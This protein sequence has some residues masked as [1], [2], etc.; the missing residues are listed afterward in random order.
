MS[1]STPHT[2]EQYG[3]R[4]ELHRSLSFGDL[5]VYGLVFM[6]P[7]APFG[8]FGGVFQGSGGMV[9]L[10]YVIG[11]VAMMFTALSYAQMSRA[12]PMAGSVYTYAGRGIAPQIGFLSG[13]MILL[14]YVLVPGLLYLIASVAMNS[15][16]SAVP[17]W[18][19]LIGF[20]VL[21]TVV[22]YMGIEMTAK[23]NRVMLVGELVVLAIFIV[24]G[25][26]AL[27]QGKGRGFDI[28]PIYNAHTFSWSLVFG[29]VSI[30]VLSFLGFDGI[31]MLAEENKESARAIG[32]SMIAA[33]LLAGVLF[34][35]QTWIAA[36]LVPH[37]GALIAKGDP[38]G[39]AFYDSA[40]VA[41]GAWLS[42]LTALA[43]A[44]AWGF[45]N[46]LVAQ[47]ATSRLLYAMARDRQLPSFLAKVHPSKGVPVNATFLTAVVSLALGLYFATRDDGI[48]LL[49]TL[50]NFGALTAF[51]ALHVSVVVHYV[52]RNG[53]RAWW[54]HLF[55]PVIGFAILAYVLINAQLQ[56]KW[57]G[58]IWFALGVVMLLVLVGMG[59]RPSLT[60]EDSGP[61]A[62]A[63]SGDQD[64]W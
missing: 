37:P 30:A 56:A 43:T 9:A 44:I 62:S 59:R 45:A 10:A 50:V 48:S 27:A 41:A 2:I 25:V 35:V 54:T 4:Q 19:W 53:S 3:Y 26:I 36:L 29:A 7:I 60:L 46:S 1:E 38:G 23:V 6:V 14:D 20:V 47:A 5:L 55:A 33:L 28:S 34:I 24:I 40:A 63:P 15:L 13:W 16:I 42:K 58:L 8:I 11:M 21:N 61:V 32:R 51:L 52:V 22:N 12:F 17:I 18:L 31:S 64:V 57:L 49:S 39:T